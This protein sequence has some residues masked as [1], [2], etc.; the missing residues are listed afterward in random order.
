MSYMRKDPKL[1][2]AFR[3]YNGTWFLEWFITDKNRAPVMR[4][5]A[6]DTEIQLI[7]RIRELELELKKRP[8]EPPEMNLGRVNAKPM[9]LK[10]KP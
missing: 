10:G 4:R 7:E 6:H 8:L 1:R 2:V 3:R 5:K 9:D